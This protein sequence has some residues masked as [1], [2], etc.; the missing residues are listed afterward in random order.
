VFKRLASFCVDKMT[1][2][3]SSY[4]DTNGIIFWVNKTM[5]SEATALFGLN[6]VIE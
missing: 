6:V 4:S 3:L 5:S 2:M 1:L